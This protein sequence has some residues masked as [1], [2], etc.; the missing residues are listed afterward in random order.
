[1][2]AT[3]YTIVDSGTP[4]VVRYSNESYEKIVKYD[5]PLTKKEIEAEMPYI[6]F[7]DKDIKYEDF[8][9]NVKVK[10]SEFRETEEDFYDGY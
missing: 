2:S 9:F 8:M 5:V 1:M 7:T 6:T 3:S 10:P 4:F